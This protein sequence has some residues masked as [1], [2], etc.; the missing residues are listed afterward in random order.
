MQAVD[1]WKKNLSPLVRSLLRIPK[2]KTF[3]L[4]QCSEALIRERS[5]RK[6]MESR[7]AG[8]LKTV[9][10]ETRTICNGKCSFCAASALN[11]IR[12]DQLMTKELYKKIICDLKRMEYPYRISPYCN[13]EP[14]LDERIFD[15]I[16]FA[17][18]E[19]PKAMVELKTNG[20]LL[21]EKKVKLLS[22]AGL[23][24]CYVNDYHVNPE[25]TTRL[26]NLCSKFPQF[27]STTF[28]YTSRNYRDKR[29]KTN[30]AGSNPDMEPLLRPFTLFC[31]RPF[32]M[33]TITTDGSVSV[34]SNDVMFANTVG[35]VTEKPL[36]EIWQGDA[37]NTMRTHLL[38]RNRDK[39]PA[40]KVCDYE[41]ISPGHEYHSFFRFLIP[42]TI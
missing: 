5:L 7:S 31:Y 30:R 16:A 17:K 38:N 24:T 35:N 1:L 32:E 6:T 25:I 42:F 9:H 26:F 21:T 11:S 12:P 39:Q 33:L 28:H 23:D 18:K 19:C 36:S 14:L 40:C 37:I 10:I 41:G 34:C 4:Y 13:N 29:W 20:I 15:F 3:L 22:K 2:I 27:G 8:I